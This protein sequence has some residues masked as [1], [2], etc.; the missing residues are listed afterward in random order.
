MPRRFV[1]GALSILALTVQGCSDD[2][3]TG[4]DWSG[5][6][7]TG[8][9]GGGTY[10]YCSGATG[11]LSA[12]FLLPSIGGDL[13]QLGDSTTYMAMATDNTGCFLTP[14]D[15][16]TGWASKQPTVLAITP[17]APMGHVASVRAVGVGTGVIQLSA[18]GLNTV[19]AE[20]QVVPRIATLQLEPASVTIRVGDSVYV[21][22]AAVD[23]AGNRNTKL[24]MDLLVDFVGR[25]PGDY[26]QRS[27]WKQNGI[28]VVGT[29]AGA[30]SVTTT[31][32]GRTAASTVTVVPR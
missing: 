8:G 25:A 30:A 5:V 26:W 19:V 29:S 16:M 13:I 9:G 6:G 3:G 27:A 10:E 17:L 15:L 20:I 12:L 18:P 11:V 21:S 23:T 31:L 14:P 4:V 1:L 32:F 7:G 28:W 2:Y 24:K 22:A